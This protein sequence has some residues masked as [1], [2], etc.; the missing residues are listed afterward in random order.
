ML[1]H[2]GKTE[3]ELK[4]EDKS[5]MSFKFLSI[6]REGEYLE[7]NLRNDE[8]TGLYRVK[9]VIH[10]VFVNETLNFARIDVE[11]V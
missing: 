2:D 4:F 6:P 10:C 5:T 3:V 11:E 8:K 7:L 9:K 1:P